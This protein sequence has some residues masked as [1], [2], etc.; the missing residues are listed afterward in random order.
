MSLPLIKNISDQMLKV[1]FH[2]EREAGFGNGRV[3]VDGF[4]I[5]EV[6]DVCEERDCEFGG[7]GNEVDANEACLKDYLNDFLKFR[8]PHGVK[9]DSDIKAIAKDV[10]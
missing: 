10:S 6:N 7:K 4:P 8:I 2:E 5:S 9:T 3:L 1:R